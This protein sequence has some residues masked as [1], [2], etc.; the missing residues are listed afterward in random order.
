[1]NLDQVFF[2]M[3]KTP[4]NLDFFIFFKENVQNALKPGFRASCFYVVKTRVS[5]VLFLR[6]KN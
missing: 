2:K 5:R 1:M 3:P 6:G 4:M